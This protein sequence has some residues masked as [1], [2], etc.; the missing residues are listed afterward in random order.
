MMILYY[1]EL[2]ARCFAPGNM[3]YHPSPHRNVHL[4]SCSLIG[5]VQKL[6]DVDRFHIRNQKSHEIDRN[7]TLINKSD[8]KAKA[9]TV[10]L[11]AQTV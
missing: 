8:V 7:T 6:W 5:P 10:I 1:Y 11:A 3:V 9:V 2:L 4:T